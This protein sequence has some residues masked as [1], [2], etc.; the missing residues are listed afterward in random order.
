MLAPWKKSDDQCNSLLKSREIT[1]LIKVHL[2][3]AM[4][5]PIVMHG[6]E[7]WTIKKV[8]CRRIDAGLDYKES[9]APK[10]WCWRCCFAVVLE[11]ILESPLDCKEI[12]LVHCKDQSW[13]FI[14]RTD[15]DVETP[16]LW[17]PDVQNWLI[18]KVPVVGK[19]WRQE[20]G[21]TEDEMFGWHHQ[22]N[23]HGFVWTMGVG[24]GQ[25]GLACCSSCGHKES[26][27]TERLNW[28]EYPVLYT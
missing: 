27:T 13:V 6:C 25:W 15:V 26:D 16:I 19:D 21:T 17:P 7:N 3:K 23:G 8:E 11:K 18:G 20:K 5:F 22:L 2:V 9:S 10:N 12:Q 28:T 24:E 4:V 1:F 14:G